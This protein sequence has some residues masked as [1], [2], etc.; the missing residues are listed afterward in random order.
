MNEALADGLRAIASNDDQRPS[1][2]KWVRVEEGRR[3]G[4][5]G[6]VLR[7]IRDPFNPHKWRY[8]DSAQGMLRDTL[9]RYGFRVQIDSPSHGVFWID[10]EK[11]TVLP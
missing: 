5:E 11:V 4:A 1:Q 10:A 6:R 9:G 3:K 2:G 7:H 8:C